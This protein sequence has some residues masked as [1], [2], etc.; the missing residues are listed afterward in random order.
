MAGLRCFCDALS[1]A[2]ATATASRL[3]SWRKSTPTAANPFVQ[4][5][6]NSALV[7]P[8]ILLPRMN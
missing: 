4:A 8:I 1:C 6:L 5:L 7:Y 3:D 2:T